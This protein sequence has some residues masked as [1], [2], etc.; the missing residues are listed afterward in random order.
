MNSIEDLIY[1]EWAE[2]NFVNDRLDDPVQYDEWIQSQNEILED[3]DI[4]YIHSI[5]ID[6]VLLKTWHKSELPNGVLIEITTPE[7]GI[8]HATTYYRTDKVLPSVKW[9]IKN[10]YDI[11]DDYQKSDEYDYSE[12]G[13]EVLLSHII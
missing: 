13:S 11:A 1:E 6:D 2:Y 9:W 3:H 4:E 8:E 10:G 12:L 7:G 5:S